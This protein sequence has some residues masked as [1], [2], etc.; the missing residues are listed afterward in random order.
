M[1]FGIVLL[2]ISWLCPP[3]AAVID[4]RSFVRHERAGFRPVF[5][6]A[7]VWSDHRIFQIDSSQLLW[8]DLAIVVIAGSAIVTLRF[9]RK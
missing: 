9:E 2:V 3:W 4:S 7:E 8:I 6:P 5:R 1:W